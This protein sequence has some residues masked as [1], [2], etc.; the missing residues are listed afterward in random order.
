MNIFKK[1]SLA[2]KLLKIYSE[3]TEHLNKTHLTDDVK[4]N[5]ELLK[6]VLENLS[7]D[8]PIVKELIGIIFKK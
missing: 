7:K 2:N 3:V 8:I 1:I 5:M 4:K 6:T